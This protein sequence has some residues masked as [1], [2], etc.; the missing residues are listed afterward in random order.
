M[1]KFLEKVDMLAEELKS[2]L[3][4]KPEYQQRL[5]KKIRLEF[6]FNSNHIEG[7]TL[8]YGETEL[9]LMFDKTTGNHEFREYEE[10]KAHDVAFEMIKGWANDTERP[11][12]EADLKNLHKVLLV[13]PFWK[14][15]ITQDGQPTRRLIEVGNYK[16]FANSVRLQNGTIFHYASPEETPIKMGELMDWYREEDGK[17]HPVTLAAMLHY[18]FV[19]IH[20]FDDG[21]GRISRLLMNY[22]LLKN[23]LPPVIIKSADKRN[24]L[25]ALNQADTGNY[26]AFILY[27]AEQLNWS[28]ELAIKAAKGEALEEQGDLDKKIALLEREL[29]QV[30]AEKEKRTQLNVLF[31]R[32]I[33]NT[34]VN[35]L[36]KQSIPVIQKFNKFFIGSSHQL[37]IEEVDIKIDF[38]DTTPQDIIER[39]NS[40]CNH[41]RDSLNIPEMTFTIQAFYDNLIKANDKTFDCNYGITVKLDNINYEIAVDT[42]DMQN[43]RRSQKVLYNRLLHVPLLTDEIKR[44]S[45]YLGYQIF[46]HIDY[47]TH[48]NGLRS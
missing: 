18:K 19:C 15:A 2:L 31:F 11:L 45:E 40:E 38:V 9:L 1:A 42:F 43:E 44:V 36:I 37:R 39:F 10:M 30:E 21:N 41:N 35:D 20:P 5:D 48:K 4:M 33:R 7:N 16:K 46:E 14:E 24:Y 34:W 26:E 22:V 32:M 27:I 47:Y 29:Q 13:R 12:N 8:T 3:P 25:F 23:N 6:N 17:I 28:L